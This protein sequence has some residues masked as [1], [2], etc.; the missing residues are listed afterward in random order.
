MGSEVRNHSFF[1]FGDGAMAPAGEIELAIT[2]R[3]MMRELRT[4]SR[5]SE[6]VFAHLLSRI[7]LR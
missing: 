5:N 7:T 3:Q 6:R 4:Y 1:V 2:I